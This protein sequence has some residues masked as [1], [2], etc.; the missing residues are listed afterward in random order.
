MT[1]HP[2]FTRFKDPKDSFSDQCLSKGKEKMVETIENTDLNKIIVNDP[3]IAEQNKLIG[4]LFQ[5]IAEIDK[6]RELTN[7]AFIANTP[8]PD[9]ER[10]PLHFPTSDPTSERFPNNSTTATIPKPPLINLTTPNPH[11][12]SSSHQ[13]LPTPHNPNTNVFQKFHLIHQT[14]TQIVQNPPTT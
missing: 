4:Q 6:T 10:P 3:I 9:S 13:K 5:Q 7:L 2:Y 14:P 12:A 11:H 8:T 1:K